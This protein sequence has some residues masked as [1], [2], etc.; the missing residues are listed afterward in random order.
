M[1]NKGKLLLTDDELYSVGLLWTALRDNSVQSGLYIFKHFFDAF[2]EAEEKFSFAH[3]KYGNISPNFMET[4]AMYDHSAAFMDALDAVMTRLFKRDPEATKRIYDVGF[5]HQMMSITEHDMTMLSSSIYSAVQDILGKKASDKDLAAW[6]HL[7]GLVSYHFKRGLL[8]EPYEHYE[9]YKKEEPPKQTERNTI[10]GNV[11]VGAQSKKSLLS[12]RK[13]RLSQRQS[14]IS[15]R[16][17]HMSQRK[18]HLNQ[19]KSQVSFKT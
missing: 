14:H 6:R 5:H 7:L 11:I 18:S 12:Q 2:P 3:D 19:K 4:K 1:A 16:K 10:H 8:G 15:Q 9:H 13:S 17:S